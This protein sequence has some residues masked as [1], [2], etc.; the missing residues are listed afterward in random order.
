MISL[1]WLTSRNPCEKWDIE[2]QKLGGGGGGNWMMDI[3]KG[4][5]DIMTTGYYIGLM[6]H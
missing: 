6:N 5:H 1:N 2:N 4:A 3:K